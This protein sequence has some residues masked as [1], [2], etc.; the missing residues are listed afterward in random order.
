[1]P[2]RYRAALS[3]ARVLTGR[4]RPEIE[5]SPNRGP[6]RCASALPLHR[7]P[8][9]RSW[10]AAAC[11]KV[12]SLCAMSNVQYGFVLFVDHAFC[13]AFDLPA[14]VVDNRRAR[15]P[16]RESDLVP[17]QFESF[18]HAADDREDHC[19]AHQL[20]YC[21]VLR[22]RA[23]VTQVAAHFFECRAQSF[24]ERRHR[25]TSIMTPVASTAMC[26]PMKTGA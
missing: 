10:C 9:R 20:E 13:T 12:A 8:A 2:R 25:P 7:S 14:R 5:Q 17:P 4:E 21:R 24:H 11:I 15:T 23:D 3:P 19:V 18:V 1:M 22:P 26:G 16:P 6:R